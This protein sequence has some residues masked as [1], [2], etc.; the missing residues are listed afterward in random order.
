MNINIEYN[1]PE[2][3]A[4][5][6]VNKYFKTLSSG[7]SRNFIR[8]YTKQCALSDI[9]NTIEFWENMAPTYLSYG[10]SLKF[11]EETREHIVSYKFF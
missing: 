3:Y 11:L 1:S 2:K 4:E 6:I 9:D 10:P 7:V 8:H 5:H